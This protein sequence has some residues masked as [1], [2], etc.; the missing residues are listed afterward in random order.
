MSG[1]NPEWSG[2]KPKGAGEGAASVTGR[3]EG[4]TF[5][6]E[7]LMALKGYVP[8]GGGWSGLPLPRGVYEVWRRWCLRPGHFGPDLA[9]YLSGNVFAEVRAPLLSVG[10]DDDPIATRRTVAALT[11]FYPN[12]ARESRWY[13]PRDIGSS[14][15]GHEGFF[16]AR[17]RDS[18]WRPVFDWIDGILRGPA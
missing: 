9:T 7:R 5:E 1:A 8:T 17:H 4:T 13:A 6:T 14:R 18:L 10:F 15:I 3:T 2:R 11:K 12:A 16:S